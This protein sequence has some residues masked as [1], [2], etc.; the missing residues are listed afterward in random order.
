MLYIRTKQMEALVWSTHARFVDRV[1][2]FM[3]TNVHYGSPLSS[4]ELR[5][6]IEQQIEKAKCYGL[7]AEQELVSYVLAAQ[8]LGANFDDNERV[9]GYLIS[10]RSPLQKSMFL[11]AIV[12]QTEKFEQDALTG[13]AQG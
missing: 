3:R 11:D 9:A 1:V 10:E 7:E 6:Q 12:L 8:L 4:V 2:E 13:G 5:E